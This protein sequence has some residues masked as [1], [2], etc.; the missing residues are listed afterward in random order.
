VS[1][2]ASSIVAVI[3]P[4]SRL[5]SPK[6]I[7]CGSPSRSIMMFC[8]LRSR[9]TTPALCAA[10]SALA[11]L[12]HKAAA[13]RGGRGFARSPG[14]RDHGTPLRAVEA[15]RYSH[16]RLHDLTSALDS[17]PD[18]ER[19]GATVEAAA[20]GAGMSRRTAYRRLEDPEFRETLE[21][22]RARVRDNLVQ[23]LADASGAAIDRLWHLVESEDENISLRAC[24]LLLGSLTKVQKIMV[25]QP[26]VTER[27]SQ[28]DAYRDGQ[29][30]LRVLRQ[31]MTRTR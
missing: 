30:H 25:K 16:A 6:S 2:K 18:T 10:W 14:V 21:Q 22:A 1:R 23:Q 31:E 8:G 24:S 19:H 26:Q 28:T 20:R 29:A 5:A 3:S 13:S 7:I 15:F 17:L 9:C 12:A 4:D 27:Y 11:I